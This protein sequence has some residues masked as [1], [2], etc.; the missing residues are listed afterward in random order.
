VQ[1]IASSVPVEPPK[2]YTL[3]VSQEELDVIVNALSNQGAQTLTSELSAYSSEP[4]PLEI[5]V[6]PI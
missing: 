6:G 2:T 1:I 5:L 4:L 3:I